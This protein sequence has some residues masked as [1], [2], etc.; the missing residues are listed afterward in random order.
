MDGERC[1]RQ[2][3]QMLHDTTLFLPQTELSSHVTDD[4]WIPDRKLKERR[5]SP[6]PRS[7]NRTE[8]RKTGCG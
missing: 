6:L 3:Q 1:C 2:P 8:Q 7:I 4:G 5:F